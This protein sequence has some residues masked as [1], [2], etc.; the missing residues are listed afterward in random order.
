MNMRI[1]LLVCVVGLLGSTSLWSDDVDTGHR[2]P[3]DPPTLTIGDPA[4]KLD[5]QHWLAATDQ[6]DTPVGAFMDGT[7]YIVEFWGT[8]CPPCITEIPHL[9]KLQ[10]RYGHESLRLIS[11]SDEPLEAVQAFLDREVPDAGGQTYRDLTS[12]FSITTDPDRSV[13]RDYVDAAKGLGVPIA[14][15]VGKTQRIEWVGHP[16]LIDAPLESVMR[17]D[18]DRETFAV[19]FKQKQD[20][21]AAVRKLSIFRQRNAER[22]EEV[23]RAID[24]EFAKFEG[25]DQPELQML[26]A[27]RVQM[28]IKLKRS[29]E[30]ERVVREMLDSPK[31]SI[32]TIGLAVSILFQIP[33]DVNID[34]ASLAQRALQRLQDA[35]PSDQFADMPVAMQ[36][37]ADTRKTMMMVQLHQLAGQNDQAVTLLKKELDKGLDSQMREAVNQLLQQISDH[38]SER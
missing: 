20:V 11:V 15:M 3:E 28:L 22:P 24:E 31:Q 27:F 4:P 38:E 9:A 30:V 19:E 18:W 29:D 16:G 7:V 36:R 10:Q 14:F 23:L 37:L 21:L 17:G 33:P 32:E 26:H 34:R 25:S 1:G 35:M 5:I 8:W 6:Q 12:V 2:V 13:H